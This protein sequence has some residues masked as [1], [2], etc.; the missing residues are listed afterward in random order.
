M[1]KSIIITKLDAAKRQL[2]TVIRLYFHYEDPVS[3]HTLVCAAYNIVH[4]IKRK[5]GGPPML[6]KDDLIKVYVKTEYQ[7][8][9][10]KKLNEP[11]NFF[12]H[13]DRDHAATIEFNSDASEFMIWDAVRGYFEITGEWTPLFQVFTGWFISVNEKIIKAEWKETYAGSAR[14][15]RNIGRT[16][17]FE[18]MLPIVLRRGTHVGRRGGKRDAA[19]P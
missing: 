12:K 19:P 13:A 7:Q 18:M 10:R 2:E 16:K 4:D 5:R 3:I 17:F 11:E 6:V 14:A 9:M 8:Q 15:A 1:E